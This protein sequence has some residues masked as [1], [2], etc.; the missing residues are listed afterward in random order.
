[1]TGNGRS[2]N[3][4]RDRHHDDR[5]QKDVKELQ[6]INTKQEA[7]IHN[8]ETKALQL[9]NLYFMFQ[10]VIL[11]TV[12]NKSLSC[13]HSWIPFVLS[14]LAAILNTAA[15]C[16]TI[17]VFVKC[18]EELDQNLEDLRVMKE[19]QLTRAELEEQQPAVR[20]R[21][22]PVAQIIRRGFSI[23]S[24]ALFVGFSIVILVA[25]FAIRC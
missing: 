8:L 15:L 14:L 12:T 6:E 24:I 22:D 25:C 13:G 4:I 2:T 11:S 10:G 18:S 1:M 17:L 19:G 23:F 7:R 20:Q 9:T 21:P 3:N 16:H 5:V